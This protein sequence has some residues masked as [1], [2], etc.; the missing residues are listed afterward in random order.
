MSINILNIQ[1]FVTAQNATGSNRGSDGIALE[2]DDSAGGAVPAGDNAVIGLQS[3]NFTSGY[4]VVLLVGPRSEYQIS[5][6]GAGNVT[7]TDTTSNTT[8]DDTGISYIL[9]GGGATTTTAGVTSYSSIYFVENATDVQI[10]T[11]YQAVLGRQPDLP[12]LEYWENAL[13]SGQS[14]VSITGDFIGSSE[15]LARFPAASAP[16]DQGG[17]H[18]TAFVTALYENILNRAPDSAGLAYWVNNL[19]TGAQDRA[20]VLISFTGSQENLANISASNGGW[21]IDEAQGGYADQGVLLPASTVLTQAISDGYLNTALAN[22]NSSATIGDVQLF[23]GVTIT[24]PTNL[25]VALSATAN[26]LG[27]YS[28]SPVNVVGAAS[29]GSTVDLNA[30]TVS[31][32]GTNNAVTVGVGGLGSVANATAA[33]SVGNFAVGDTLDFGG[34]TTPVQ[35]V[36]ATASSPVSAAT[37]MADTAHIHAISVGNVGGGTVADV[38]AAADAVVVPTTA[39]IEN[40]LFIGQAGADTVIYSF[41]DKDYFSA[42]GGTHATGP[43]TFSSDP[44]DVVYGV[45]LTGVQASTLTAAN[46][47]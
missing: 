10:A 16:A 43:A 41:N 34:A 4:N 33:V 24:G 15:F 21:L 8:V 44:G 28:S 25:T 31:L 11:F 47:N 38:L 2:Y 1:A 22:P 6:D 26:F 23:G 40:F 18:D 9:F 36:T 45:R 17:P 12:G 29:G 30:G 35:I 32:S 13:T 37:L 5:V 27:D 39:Q 42:N 7:I 20:E 46:F 14:L 3:A 19:A